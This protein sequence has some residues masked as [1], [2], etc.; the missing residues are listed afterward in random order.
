MSRPRYVIEFD[1]NTLTAVLK[2]WDG[3]LR[4][5]WETIGYQEGF[6]SLQAAHIYFGSVIMEDARK[7]RQ[8][9]IQRA[10]FDDNGKEINHYV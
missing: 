6:V 1:P 8:M 7:R 2:R 4:G 10:E 3:W 5:K 9:E